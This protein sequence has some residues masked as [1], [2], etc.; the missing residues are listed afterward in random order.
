MDIKE[1]LDILS[2]LISFPS[3]ND[4]EK[5]VAIYLQ[6]LLQEH[7]ISSQ[8]LPLEGDRANLVAEIGSG[9]PVLALSGHMDVVDVQRDNWQTDPFKLT[10][11]DDKLYGRGSTDMKSGLAAMVIAL[12]EL[13]ESNFQF[14]GTIRFLAT[15]GEE[16][17]QYGAE[18]L[19]KQGYMQDVDSLLIG[20]PSGYIVVYASKGELDLKIQSFGKAAHSS[21]PALGNNAVEHLLRVLNQIESQL[22][23]LMATA[24]NDVLGKT[25]FNIDVIKGGQQPNAIPGYAEAVLNIRT[26][27]ELANQKILDTI[28]NVI[29]HYNATTTGQINLVC[30]MNIIPILGNKD[31]KLIK[32][33]QKI[34]QPYLQKQNYSAEEIEQLEKQAQLSGIPFSADEILTVGVSGG[35]DA[36]KFLIDQPQGFNYVV[37]GPGNGNAHQDNEFVSQTMY[38]DFIDIYQQIIKEYFK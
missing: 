2:K 19:Q 35:T 33:I 30:D 32:L 1:K 5:Q 26:I 14:P 4:H 8:I 38:L 11:V 25:L 15:S 16:V 37:F 17:G 24:E 18:T 6:K 28:Q 21:M 7:N 31:A 10:S 9:K 13:Q 23:D 12:I 27:P 22:S 29:E 36:S 34:A 3:V 20:E